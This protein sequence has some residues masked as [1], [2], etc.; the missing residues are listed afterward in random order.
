MNI[1]Q[2]LDWILNFRHPLLTQIFSIFPYFASD[3]F[4]ISII[5]IGYWY[6]PKKRTF[7][8]L[9]FLVPFSTIINCL[10]KN[11]FAI[12]RPP[13]YLHLQVVQDLF[14]FP[15][16]D[17]QVATVFW[18]ILFLHSQSKIIKAIAIMTV[19]CIMVSRVY[20]G[21]HSPL[22]VVAGLLF[23]I[24]ILLIW[25]TSLA[26]SMV[27]NW[28]NGKVK[29]FWLA[30]AS[31]VTFYILMSL[32]KL[33]Q[34]MVMMAIGALIGFGL[35]LPSMRANKPLNVDVGFNK[36]AVILL[37]FITL[38]II[39]K[40]IPVVKGSYLLYWLSGIVKYAIVVLMIYSFI[41]KAQRFFQPVR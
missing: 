14:G 39:V 27:M 17:V 28:I 31:I 8:D 34:P 24:M 15:S 6:N 7:T 16:G 33:W 20:L 18:G 13:S 32:T 30:L 9:G 4:Y 40:I 11:G 35:S 36:L 22:D 2:D 19:K 5:A 10:L 29:S 26:Q 21:V 25:H 23:G 41:P 12:A 38:I 3:Y 37:S 1:L